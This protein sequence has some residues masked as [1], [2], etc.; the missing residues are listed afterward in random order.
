MIYFFPPWL[1]LFYFLFCITSCDNLKE[2]LSDSKGIRRYQQQAKLSR[3][4]KA[5]VPKN[6][7]VNNKMLA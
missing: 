1:I 4:F 2:T 5:H 7:I 3:C 6:F